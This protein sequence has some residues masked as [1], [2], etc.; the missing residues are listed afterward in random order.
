MEL[1]GYFAAV[2]SNKASSLSL[3]KL[4]LRRSTLSSL[5]F[6][7][8][9]LS[10]YMFLAASVNSYSSFD[11][12]VWLSQACGVVRSTVKQWVHKASHKDQSSLTGGKKRKNIHFSWSSIVQQQ[13]SGIQGKFKTHF[14]RDC[15]NLLFTGK[16]TQEE[17]EI[18]HAIHNPKIFAS[19]FFF[20]RW[21]HYRSPLLSIEKRARP[22]L[23]VLGSLETQQR[24][25]ASNIVLIHIW[26]LKALKDGKTGL[27]PFVIIS[28]TLNSNF[29]GKY[30]SLGTYWAQKEEHFA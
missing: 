8:V 3:T 15:R 30:Q 11:L 6:P 20:C 2:F 17:D 19:F 12:P 26:A 16:G 24:N 13:Y 14:W 4:Y 25:L 10:L 22:Q 21:C 1:L 9:Y 18:Q 28:G 5:W 29:D 27:F 23:V 7:S